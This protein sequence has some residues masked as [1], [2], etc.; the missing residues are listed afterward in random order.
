PNPDLIEA[1]VRVTDLVPELRVVIDHVPA[2]LRTLSPEARA[3]VDENF[4]IL[5]ARPQVYVKVS[6]VLIVDGGQ[7]VTD[8]A[9]YKP[10]LDYLFQTFGENQ[11]V[12]GSDW[13]NSV[14]ATN[15]PAVL[16]IVQDYF[17]AKGFGVAEKYFWKNSIAA[18]KWVRREFSQPQLTTT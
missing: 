16:Q 14:A 8:P 7:P 15:L 13:P 5:A 2:M 4:R 9:V 3:G 11:L 10:N 18:Y 17:F 6:E 1:V 12:F